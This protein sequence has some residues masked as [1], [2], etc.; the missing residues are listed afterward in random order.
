MPLR[1]VLKRSGM[2]ILANVLN[3]LKKLLKKHSKNSAAIVMESGAQI[4]GGV[5]IFP[6]NFQKNVS[7]LSKKYNVLLILD[8]VVYWLWQVGE[9]DRISCTGF[10]P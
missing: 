6:Q 5:K 7:L 3:K 4:A 2:K 10:R 1:L 9:Y 8:E